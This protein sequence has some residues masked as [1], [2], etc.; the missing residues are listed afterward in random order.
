MPLGRWCAAQGG[1]CA[2]VRLCVWAWRG[3]VARRK[4]R[5]TRVLLRPWKPPRPPGHERGNHCVCATQPG[6]GCGV[7]SSRGRAGCGGGREG[8]PHALRGQSL[9]PPHP[10]VCACDRRAG[11][12][13]ALEPKSTR[14]AGQPQVLFQVCGRGVTSGLKFEQL[15]FQSQADGRPE[16]CVS[17]GGAEPLAKRV[18]RAARARPV[19]NKNAGTVGSFSNKPLSPK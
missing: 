12:G 8:S 15:V 2:A 9:P 6:A 5:A 19:K 3:G 14:V 16:A 13:R 7:C 17:T 11:R 4:T 10:R 1:P 18:C